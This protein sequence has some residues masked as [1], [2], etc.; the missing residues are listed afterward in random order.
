M[1]RR[2]FLK[3]GAIALS[4]GQPVSAQSERRQWVLEN[5]QMAWHLEQTA[6]GIRSVSFEN[7]VSGRRFA[8]ETESEFTLVFS[9][10]ERCEIPWWDSRYTDDGPIAPEQESGLAQGFHR[11]GVAP[12]TWAQAANLSGGRKG[13]VYDGYAWFRHNFSLP[14]SARGKEIVFVLGGYDQQDW[15]ER[16]VYLNGGEAGHFQGRGRW[17]TPGYSV[18]RPAEPLYASLHFG[19]ESSNIL[20]V[21]T[22]GYDFRSGDIPDEVLNRQVFRPFLFDQFV[23]IGTPFRSISKFEMMDSRREGPEKIRF[24]LRDAERLWNVVVHYELNGFVRRKWLEVRNESSHAELLLDVELDRF[25]VD[26]QGTEG[27]QGDPVLLENEAFFAL[28]HPAGV[29]QNTAGT[30]RL[31]HAPGKQIGPGETLKSVVSLAGVTPRDQVLDRFHGYIVSRSP[32]VRKKHISLFTCYG[33]NNQWGGCPALTDAE[34]LDCQ[35]VVRSWQSK[36]VK[37]DYFTLDQGWPDNA[38][39]LTEFA[40]ACYPDGPEKIIRGIQELGMKFGLWFSVSGG[41]WSDGSYQAVQSSAIPAPGNSGV[42]PDAPPVTQYRNGYPAS[43][44][45]G[46][47]LCVSSEPYFKVLKSAIEHH[48]RHNHLRLLKLDIGDYYCNSTHHQHLPGRYSTEAMF[49]RL[50]DIAES[51][52]AIAPDVFVVWYWGV[53]AS[54]FWGLYGDTIFESGLFMEGSGTSWYPSLYYRDSVTL[55]LDQSTRFA[56]FVPPLL[57]DSLGV[58]LSQIRWANFMGKSRWREALIMDLGRGNLMFPQLWGDPNLLGDD[59]LRFLS[60][61][62]AFARNHETTLLS[63]RRDV[64]DAMKNDP[65]GYAFFEGARGLVFC[66]NMH[67]RARKMKLPLGPEIGWT[68]RTGAALQLTSY[69]PEKEELLAEDG[70]TFRTGAVAEFWMRPFE[71]LLLQIGATAPSKLPQRRLTASGAA[72]YGTDLSLGSD[73]PAPWMQLKFADQEHFEKAGMRPAMT[74]YSVRLPRLPDGRS[75]LAIHVKLRRG[76]EEYRY[77]PA[78]AEIVQLRARLGGH[79]IQLIPVPDARQYGNTQH[80][81]YSWVVYKIPL[82]A[83]HSEQLLEFAVHSYL[84]TGTEALTE[85]WLVK[86]W[87]EE[88]TRPEAGGYY[89]QAPS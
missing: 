11:P 1:D 71:T 31:W 51:A 53:G 50:I 82:G 60:Q 42:P 24:V 4:L 61:I 67:F 36:G 39:D 20:A 84:P 6:D 28:E 64:G 86:Q 87:W 41:G 73:E 12:G 5:S 70:S 26:G 77:S 33:I 34:V 30:I 52:R 68:A 72:A 79:D 19:P 32:R 62:M 27:G 48:V 76:R 88:S 80:A 58:W 81:G 74:C 45:V 15:H 7:R 75:V 35:R 59:D 10:G 43:G 21:R 18:L 69:F 9:S 55:S 17:R 23:S 16:W 85:A 66:H 38:G 37:F 46:R 25:H 78:V 44:G 14:E 83:A 56:R 13:R 8:L 22:R 57:K 47:T 89:G 54:P 2:Q 63:P 65:Y 40:T 29:N 3:E 49:N